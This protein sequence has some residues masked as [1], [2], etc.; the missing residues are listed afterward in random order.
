M[1]RSTLD[2]LARAPVGRYV[3]GETFA[4][5]CAAP[6]LWG[7]VLW[8]RPD[9]RHA[10]EL[11]R[12]LPLE[13]RAPAV[14][15]ASIVD[16]SRLE[17]GDPQAFGAAERYLARHG[18]KLASCVRRLALVRPRGLGGAIVAGAYEVLPRPYPVEVFGDAASAFAWLA[19]ERA[20]DWPKDGAAA[21]AE[22]YAE[23][24]GTPHVVG[25]LRAILDEKLGGASV[26]EAAGALG[27]S[28]RTLQ[29]KLGE[30][31]TTLQDEVAA[32]RIRAAERLLLDSD[33]PLTAIA[34]DVGCAS[35]Q[36]FS[37]L[38]RKR[39]GESPSAFR[40]RRKPK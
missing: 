8:G 16:A 5:F 17:G 9:A 10:A 24:S 35:L 19:S 40:K 7:V 32:A 27:L 12:S 26:A 3:A 37:A 20:R 2:E 30:A 14:P 4:H 25:A 31:R 28:E 33:A 1:R 13:L 39:T 21:L 38:F 29:R 22:I 23:A 18:A 6:T 34:F 36:H 15:H 11:G